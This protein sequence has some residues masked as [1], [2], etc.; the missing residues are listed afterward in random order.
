MKE[1]KDLLNFFIAAPELLPDFNMLPG[2]RKDPFMES[3]NEYES[4][5]FLRKDMIVAMDMPYF[6]LK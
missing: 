1:N 5:K 2:E 4:M 6:D 3:L